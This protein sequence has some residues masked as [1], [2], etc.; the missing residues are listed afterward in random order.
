VLD[1]LQPNLQI[2]NQIQD[3]LVTNTAFDFIIIHPFACFLV[4]SIAG[5]RDSSF[6]LQS[7]LIYFLQN[8]R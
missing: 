3:P 8:Y 5:D 7:A 2:S 6:Y 4:K 1:E